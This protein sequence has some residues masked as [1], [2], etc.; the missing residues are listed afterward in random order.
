MG[1]LNVTEGEPD[2]RGHA[3]KSSWTRAGHHPQL[4][5]LSVQWNGPR[6]TQ[7][8]LQH[9][10]YNSESNGANGNGNRMFCRNFS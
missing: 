3:E 9:R 7:A 1:R 4:S 2:C 10:L 8:L 6:E 5:D